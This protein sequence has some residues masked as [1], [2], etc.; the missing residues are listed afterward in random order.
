MDTDQSDIIRKKICLT[1]YHNDL[2]NEIVEKRHVSRSEAVRAS[3]QHRAQ[4]LSDDT[5]IESLRT[6]LKQIAKTIDTI[7][8]KID[9][10]NS[11]V[12]HVPEQSSSSAENSASETKA[13]T[14]NKIVRELTKSDPLSVDEIA[15][16]IEDDIISVIP[17][18]KS[19]QQKEI[20]SSVSE[21]DNKF[22]I[23][24]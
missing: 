7:R 23:D 15:E 17:A 8:E 13:E 1:E 5:D 21:N 16:R 3:I 11:G 19:L 12:D 9:E 18:T 10:K 14:E 20:I 4:Y 6:E 22:K 24:I 2:L